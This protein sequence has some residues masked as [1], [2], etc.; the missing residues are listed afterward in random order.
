VIAGL[1]A[2]LAVSEADDDA[3]PVTA[4]DPT[5]IETVWFAFFVDDVTVH[6][7]VVLRPNAGDQV[8]T[9]RAWRGDGQALAE[10]A[11]HGPLAALPDLRDA[12][13]PNGLHL[14]CEEPLRRY[15]LTLD[16][17][18]LSFAVTFDA[19]MEPNPVSPEESPG[20]FLGHLEQ[21]GRVHPFAQ[22]VHGYRSIS[23]EPRHA[24]RARNRIRQQHIKHF[25]FW[26]ARSP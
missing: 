13:W 24:V 9:V 25:F 15:H 7:R 18:D 5:W 12:A 6:A 4:D 20:M 3:H 21:P 16:G 10:R 11:S 22:H 2:G 26:C 8:A 1:P 14:R 17:D 19:V 23:R